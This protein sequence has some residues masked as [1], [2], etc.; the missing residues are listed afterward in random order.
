MSKVR[1]NRGRHKVCGTP[2]NHCMLSA[3]TKGLT[4]S[5]RGAA[6]VGPAWTAA[7]ARGAAKVMFE[8]ARDRRG[9]KRS[10]GPRARPRTLCAGARRG[11][12]SR[13]ACASGTPL[14]DTRRPPA[15]SGLMRRRHARL[16]A[17]PRTSSAR[18]T[19]CQRGRCSPR[20]TRTPSAH[21]CTRATRRCAAL[22]R[23]LGWSARR[24]RVARGGRGGGA[25][26][27]R[28][29][30]GRAWRRTR[31]LE[32][33]RGRRES[34]REAS[35]LYISSRTA[36]VLEVVGRE[37]RRSVG[38]HPN[39]RESRSVRRRARAVRLRV[40]DGDGSS[41]CG[42][43]SPSEPKTRADGPPFNPGSPSDD[44]HQPDGRQRRGLS[45]RDSACVFINRF[46]GANNWVARNYDKRS[47]SASSATVATVCPTLVHS[48]SS[49]FLTLART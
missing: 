25:Q 20:G 22:Q 5:Q 33:S 39:A 37:S 21:T 10:N 6:S 14:Q 41:V 11:C 28:G 23:V 16:L 44:G 40:D 48:F 8:S 19:G 46:A 49:S 12:R 17:A 31:T 2:Y 34:G 43:L 29:A 13:G 38:V 4:M 9:E 18:G 47:D 30:C 26:G 42:T 45:D 27:A 36:C 15:R 24:T 7:A 1:V 35:A 3:L 32:L